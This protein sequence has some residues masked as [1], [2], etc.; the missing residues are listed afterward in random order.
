MQQPSVYFL[1]RGPQ[2]DKERLEQAAE[3]MSQALFGP[4][5]LGRCQTLCLREKFGICVWDTSRAGLP[6]PGLALEVSS[7]L[8]KGKRKDRRRSFPTTPKLCSGGKL[9]K[10]I[11]FAVA[12]EGDILCLYSV[13]G[14]PEERSNPTQKGEISNVNAR[15]F[16]PTM[17][18][19]YRVKARDGEVGT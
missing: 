11:I 8:Q 16:I 14:Q 10:P 7:R 18:P 1:N 4:Q 2:L 9:A 15:I 5:S 3:E 6:Q 17:L 13:L 19:G 12:H